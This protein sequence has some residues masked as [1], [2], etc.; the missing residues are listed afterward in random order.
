MLTKRIITFI[1]TRDQRASQLIY[2]EDSDKVLFSVRDLAET[3]EDAYIDR[4]IPSACEVIDDVV[5]PIL[6]TS[7]VF[8]IE[9]ID[10][11]AYWFINKFEEDNQEVC[12]EELKKDY[13]DMDAYELLTEYRKHYKKQ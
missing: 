2:D 1:S 9:F 8:N 3:P 4:S 13:L 10:I 6:F 5:K 12:P 7:K 11:S